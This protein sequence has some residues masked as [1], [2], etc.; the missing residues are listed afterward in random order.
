MIWQRAGVNAYSNASNFGVHAFCY[1][2]GPIDDRLNAR[3]FK[4]RPALYMGAKCFGA[5]HK[6]IWLR[7][8]Q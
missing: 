8:H 3:Q 1:L 5:N 6:G 2:D 4:V 7:A